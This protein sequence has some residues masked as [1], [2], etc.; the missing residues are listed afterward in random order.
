MCQY[1]LKQELILIEYISVIY[2]QGLQCFLNY[3]C[4]KDQETV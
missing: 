2:I 3:I 4:I 1:I